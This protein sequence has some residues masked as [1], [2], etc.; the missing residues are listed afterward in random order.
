VHSAPNENQRVGAGIVHDVL[1]LRVG[2]DG[3]MEHA[4]GIVELQ[5]DNLL[6][7]STTMSCSQHPG[8]RQGKE[9]LVCYLDQLINGYKPD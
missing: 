7:L 4:D 9:Y 1:V 5:Q 2:R 3:I 8:H 6:Y